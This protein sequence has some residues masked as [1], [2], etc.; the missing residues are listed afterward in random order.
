MRTI[1]GDMMKGL[2][3]K[4][5]SGH[6]MESGAAPVPLADVPSAVPAAGGP[7]RAHTP[8][9]Q[10]QA[11]FPLHRV[12]ERVSQMCETRKMRRI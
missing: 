6:K 5:I 11:V 10:V 7:L 12:N 1:T 2:C 9:R 3:G 4:Q 8:V